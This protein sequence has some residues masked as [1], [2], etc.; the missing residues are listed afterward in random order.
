MGDLTDKM[1]Q[2][3]LTMLD[4]AATNDLQLIVTCTF[5][6]NEEQAKLYAMGRIRDQI[7]NKIYELEE[8]YQRK[9]LAD[10]LRAATPAP[11]PGRVVT[12]A[13]P[14]QS[15]HQYGMAIDCVPLVAGKPMWDD[16]HPSWKRYGDCC[17][18]AG[19]EWAGH[20][21]RFREFP[22]A[23]LRDVDWKTLIKKP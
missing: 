4:L 5:R 6:S 17:E 14:G 18:L 9:D 3:V 22:H 20:W 19:L 2:Q 11:S 15:M 7:E 13:G 21:T 1:R 16:G 12:M 10:I 23:Q 8:V